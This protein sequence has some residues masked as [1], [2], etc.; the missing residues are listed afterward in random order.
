[1]QDSDVGSIATADVD[2]DGDQ[3]LFITGNP[4]IKSSL[5]LNDGNGNFTESVQLAIIDVYSGYSEFA[6]IDNDGDMDLLVTGN[7]SSPS[8]TTSLYLN[9]GLGNYSIVSTPFEPSNSGD[10][11]FG[12]IDNDNDLDLLIT[13]LNSTGIPFSHLYENLG[14]GSFSLIDS[15]TFIDVWSSSVEFI[16]FNNDSSLDLIICGADISNAST[17]T[18]YENNGTGDFSIV[19]TTP[20]SG[21]Q[22]GDIAYGDID[23]DGD[24]DIFLAGLN[25]SGLPIAELYENIGSVYNLIPGTPFPG[26]H[27]H[28]SNFA[29]FNNDGNLDFLHVGNSLNGLIGHVYENQGSN[30]F[31]LAD[32]TLAGSYLGA[33]AIA[34]FNGDN[35]LDIITTGTSFTAPFRAPKIYFNQS[36]VSII[37]LG[38]K[39]SNLKAYP[40]PVNNSFTIQ[41]NSS[42]D[43][44]SLIIM[45]AS[46]KLIGNKN[47]N[48]VDLIE[49]ELNQ[50]KGVYLIEVSDG[51]N[52]RSLIR[53]IKQ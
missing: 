45:D 33:S 23:N 18:L 32:S 16:D 13:G 19:N 10:I 43:Y 36:A 5:Y 8:T 1:L 6:D 12:D 14:S 53:L 35:K 34:D 15:T 28:S 31:V 22:N 49:Y 50:P 48:Q 42:Q 20:F 44:I 51:E 38:L 30:N 11:D 9:D 24:T 2:L 40:N 21:I 52:Q 39:Q 37:E 27:V 4:P 25:G 46:G 47:Y 26:T 29:D 41:F 7:T 3:D 17:T